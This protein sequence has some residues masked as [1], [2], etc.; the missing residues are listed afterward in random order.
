MGYHEKKWKNDD[1]A[2]TELYGAN[3]KRDTFFKLK[4]DLYEKLMQVFPIINLIN[5]ED[6]EY[7]RAYWECQTNF[8]IGN[9]FT[10]MGIDT[11]IGT[12]ILEKNL[13]KSIKYEF[14]NIVSES[15]SILGAYSKNINIDKKKA[16]GYDA[17]AYNYVMLRMAEIKGRIYLTE[18]YSYYAMST[19]TK[20]NVPSQIK[21]YLGDLEKIPLQVY[22][23]KLIYYKKILGVMYWMSQYN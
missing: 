17:M 11:S 23:Q 19:A 13:A 8:H 3:A 16:A 18:I 9:L 6:G 14:T 1:E 7:R 20:T 21:E 5:A 22:S 12:A 2:I 15:A 10:F 4:H